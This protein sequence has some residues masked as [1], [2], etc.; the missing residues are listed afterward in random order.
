[1]QVKL[2]HTRLDGLGASEKGLLN[3]PQQ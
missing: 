2:G 1:V 3:H